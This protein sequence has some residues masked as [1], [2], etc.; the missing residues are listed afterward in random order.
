M[1]AHTPRC[2]CA[3]PPLTRT[4][5]LAAASSCP[6][7]AGRRT[8][9]SA[10]PS[11]ATHARTVR[12]VRT[13]ARSCAHLRGA[14]D[15]EVHRV[16][17][18]KVFTRQADVMTVEEFKAKVHPCVPGVCG[19]SQTRAVTRAARHRSYGT[20]G[21]APALPLP[22]PL[23][24]IDNKVCVCARGRACTLRARVPLTRT[25]WPAGHVHVQDGGGSPPHDPAEH[26]DPRARRLARRG[27]RAHGAGA[28]H[29]RGEGG[30]RG[31]GGAGGVQGDTRGGRGRG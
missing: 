24:A 18:Q 7:C 8:G 31:A 16:L 28:V 25:C 9:T 4:L 15:E 17:T 26:R 2:G 1:R 12:L 6:L 10:S 3:R 29:A 21:P 22:A 20:D 23:V 11:S 19:H 14:G 13:R 5:S 30:V 27:R